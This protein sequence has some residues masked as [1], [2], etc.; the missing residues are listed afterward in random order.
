M[1]E[2]LGS[3][4]NLTLQILLSL[5]L[6]LVLSFVKISIIFLHGLCT[7]I[8]PENLNQNNTGNGLRPAIRRPSSTDDPKSNVEVRRRNR[9]KDKSE[10]DESNA[11]IFRI[12][13]DEDHLRSRMYFT[14]Y[15][16]LFV[17]SFLAVSCFL[18]D[19]Y[20]GIIEDNSH[21]VLSNGL[22]FPIVLGFI[23]LCKVFVAL[24]KI[25]IERSASKESE[26]RLSLIF[27]VL[28][29]VFGIIISAGV[30][31]KGFDFQ[32]GS[33]DAFCCIVISFSMACIG[34]FLYMPA[35]R[36][37]RS[38]WVGTDQIRSNLSIISCGWFGRMI[39]Y[40]NYIVSVFTSLLWIHP[41]AEVLVKRSGDPGTSGSSQSQS[42]LVGNV[43]MLSDD[44]AKFRVLC[45]LLS[46]LL[47]AMAVRPNLQMFLN[48]AVL[49]WYQRL[50]GSK[51]PDL[52]FSRAKMFLHNHYLC[53]VA[54]QFLAPSVLVILFLGLSQ[55]DLSSFAVS[56]LVCG[57]LPCSD[58]IKQVGLLMSWW[59]LF[60]WSGFTSASLVFYRRGVLYVS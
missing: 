24:G 11:Q 13:L 27:G 48:E 16:S 47:Q 15:N 41:L 45:L 2:L 35:G 1:L 14:E 60:V 56:Q 36:S 20:F 12:K 49:S 30:F 53:L 9:S 43:G 29:F 33:V 4:R 32:L 8:Q 25:S 31:P 52:D 59:V 6:T 34:G 39:L 37:A 17:I 22:M 10:F 44:F 58:F 23:A 5:F 21:G 3:Y 18:L 57:S 55:I 51:T 7:Y 28:G 26:K 50:H 42:G 54:L 38:F 19:K 46:G 40:A